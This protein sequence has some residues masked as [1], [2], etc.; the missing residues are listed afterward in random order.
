[1]PAI[2]T[3]TPQ[4][5]LVLNPG[6]GL[7][8]LISNN[9][10]DDAESAALMNVQFVESGCPSK[11]PGYSLLATT[12]NNPRGL[13]FF[14]DTP[15]SARYLLTVDGA[16]LVNVAN[17]T[18]STISGCTFSTT[19]TISMT[20]AAG[21]M[22]IWDGV[23]G[24]A[25]VVSGGTLSRTGTMPSAQFSIFYQGYHIAAGTETNPNRIYLSAQYARGQFT[26]ASGSAQEPPL[27]NNSADVPGATV[28]TSGSSGANIVDIAKDDGDHITG[29]ALFQD[30]LIIFKEWSIY[31]LTFD[32]SSGAPIVTMI[33]QAYGCVSF[34]SVTRVENDVFF[35]TRNG[36]YVLGYE[37][38]YFTII[39]TNELSARIHPIIETINPTQF[40][41]CTAIFQQY[42][43]Y[44]SVPSGGSSTNNLTL[45]YD[46]R[47][48]A[49]SQWNHVQ[50]ES[51]CSFTDANN[52]QNVYY[53]SANSNQIFMFTSN[54]NA[55]GSAIQTSWT[56]KAY[57]LGNYNIYKR[58]IDCAIFFRQ[59]SG[60]VQVNFIT[61]D[62]TIIANFAINSSTTGGI[63]SDL[64]GAFEFGGDVLSSAS[65][66]VNTN[67]VPYRFPINV[68]SRTIQ[69]QV[70]NNNINE[71]FVVLGI[72]FR[73]RLYSTFLWSSAYKVYAT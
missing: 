55:N 50:A 3:P 4:Q 54:Y 22:Y 38:D 49:W 10:I 44:C 32:P 71:N 56:S 67:N 6:K 1:M 57:D 30:D 46:R 18:P 21:A 7:N 29:L 60:S 72:A 69:V 47:Y 25:Q 26:N 12:T 33:T 2:T 64:I 53:T 43:W 45:T 9:L 27:P 61:D 58:W 65:D 5:M 42:T 52:N 40:K 34:K 17:G 11:A 24:G 70:I 15:N 23:N 31:Q 41:Q 8:N 59:L 14:N 20:Q 16:N 73:Y 66:T 39:R 13:G 35:L 36:V 19:G 63:G 51:L 62:G 48:E 68:K 28:F 37:P